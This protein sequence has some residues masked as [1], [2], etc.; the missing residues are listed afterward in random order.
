MSRVGLT[1]QE[2]RFFG[3]MYYVWVSETEAFLTKSLDV[4]R[5]ISMNAIILHKLGVKR[6]HRKSKDGYLK[7]RFVGYE[8]E[9]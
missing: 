5:I 7:N 1:E 9:R 4:A 8:D 3:Y 2:G 6:K